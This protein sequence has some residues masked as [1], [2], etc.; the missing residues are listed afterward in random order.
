MTPKPA[1]VPKPVSGAPP[2]PAAKPLGSAV[3]ERLLKGARRGETL[4]RVIPAPN[5]LLFRY[6]VGQGRPTAI[7][8]YGGVGKTWLAIDLALGVASGSKACFGH[9]NMIGDPGLKADTVIE[10]G[11]VLHLDYEM[12][13]NIIDKRY[14]RVAFG[15]GIDLCALAD[16]LTVVSHPEVNLETSTMELA[17][18]KVCIG[19]SLCII[20]SFRAAAPSADE[21]SSESRKYL[22]LLTRVSNRT[23][24]VFVVLFHEAKQNAANGRAQG[25]LMRG[26]SALFDAAGAVLSVQQADDGDMTITQTK[27]SL[28]RPGVPIHV[29]LEDVGDEDTAWWLSRGL[30]LVAVDPEA[31][32]NGKKNEKDAKAIDQ[33]K[34]SALDALKAHGEL[35][36]RQLRAKMNG[37]TDTRR[38]A[39][40]LLEESGEIVRPE[41]KNGTERPY[42]LATLPQ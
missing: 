32:R 4:A 40:A 11:T 41:G 31:K 22:D 24:T 20:D 39:I 1:L 2:K 42:R 12:G 26:S 7:V 14:Q 27:A 3:A 17:L 21:N 25:Q 36:V 38:V 23:G 34:Q 18:V 37:S 33:A 29:R 35:G 30:K 5:L 15:R 8:S 6:G 9:E 13:A 16:K 19:I 28:T 10:R